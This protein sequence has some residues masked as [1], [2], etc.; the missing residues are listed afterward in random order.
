MGGK[1]KAWDPVVFGA[2]EVEKGGSQFFNAS[3]VEKDETESVPLISGYWM[4]MTKY[5][6]KAS[7]SHFLFFNSHWKHGYGMEQAEKIAEAIHEIRTRH[8]SPP[9]IL[10]GDT[11]Q[12]CIAH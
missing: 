6:H 3:V 2:Q 7:G 10:V 12:F 8:G 1:V 5:R 9:T 4:S 11:N